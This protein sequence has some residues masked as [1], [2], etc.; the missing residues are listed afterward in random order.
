[1]NLIK[2]QQQGRLNAGAAA[3]LV[4]WCGAVL[5]ACGGGGPA[6][7]STPS[8]ASRHAAA[9][10]SPRTVRLEGCVVDEYYLPRTGIAVR[11]L[12]ADGRL[13]GDATSDLRGAYLL[14]V[15]AR[16]TVSVAVAQPNGDALRVPIGSTDVSIGACLRTT[17]SD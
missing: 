11:A 9:S 8:T 1:M 7:D 15:P 12:S 2:R 5:A 4:A 13:I 10:P 16:A 3:T 17:S 6:T 14:R